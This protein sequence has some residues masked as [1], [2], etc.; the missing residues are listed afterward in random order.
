[1][2]VAAVLL[3]QGGYYAL[4]GIAPFVSR[5]AFEGVTGPKHDWWLVQT[6]GGV[7]T[8]VGVGLIAAG[9]RGRVTAELVG[10]AAG[11]AA[12]LAT[13]DV[14]HAARS[15]ISKIYLVDAACQVAFLASLRRAV[16]Q[17]GVT[18]HAREAG[19]HGM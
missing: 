2:T 14:Y 9:A 16:A 13:I 10:I 15:R 7:V 1:M 19:R 8:P 11:C 3:A 4:T 6:V 5:R 18:R 17:S 12:G